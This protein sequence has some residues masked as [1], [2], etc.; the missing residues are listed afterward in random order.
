[1]TIVLTG[2]MVL[3]QQTL[4]TLSTPEATAEWQA[5]R[6]SVSVHEGNQGPVQRRVPEVTEPPGLILMRDYY[7][8]SVAAVVVFGTFLFVITTIAVRG[9]MSPIV[10]PSEDR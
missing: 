3:R 7:G 5:W 10:L 6:D 1:M 2:L 9:V 8:V 4:V